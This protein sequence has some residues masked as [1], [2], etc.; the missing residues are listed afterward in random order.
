MMRDIMY[1][2]AFL[3][4][5]TLMFSVAGGIFWVFA[6]DETDA[7]SAVAAAEERIV[8]CYQAVAD[9]DG[10]GANVTVLLFVLNEAGELFSKAALAYEMGNFGSALDFALLSQKR[11]SGFV[12]EAD[13]LRED[14]MQQ[15]YWDFLVNVVGSIVGSV[16]VVCGGFVVW[17]F[18]KRKYEK[19]GSM[20]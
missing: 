2:L 20:V 6:V 4:A 13:V 8:V 9:A 11:L 16:V 18:L 10:V 12:G 5:L 7:R 19:A 15:S 3:A 14:A 1:K 17:F